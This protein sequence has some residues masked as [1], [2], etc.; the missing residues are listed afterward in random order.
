MIIMRP[1]NDIMYVGALQDFGEPF[2]AL[3]VDVAKRQL[4]LM[5]RVNPESEELD[6]AVADVT[7]CEV[8]AYMHADVSL[9]K[10]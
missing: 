3:Y 4:Y 2:V 5:V 8:E 9:S 1:T 7:P 10:I 6:Y